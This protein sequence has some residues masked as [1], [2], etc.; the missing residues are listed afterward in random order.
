VLVTV[1]AAAFGDPPPRIRPKVIEKKLKEK[2]GQLEAVFE[3]EVTFLSSKV[4]ILQFT[5]RK[6]AVG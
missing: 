4:P 5:C 3:V 2:E 1:S 6:L